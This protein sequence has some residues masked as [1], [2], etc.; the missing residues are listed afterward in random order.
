MANP[1]AS[2]ASN[3]SWTPI[4][5]NRSGN[6]FLNEVFFVESVRSAQSTTMDASFAAASTTP[7]PYPSRVGFC[8][9]SLA[10]GLGIKK[11]EVGILTFCGMVTFQFL[12][13]CAQLFQCLLCLSGLKRLTV[14]HVAI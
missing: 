8:S 14:P 1:A 9:T 10:N 2:E 5:M 12:F 11:G 4:W 3:C 6:C 7:K 13:C